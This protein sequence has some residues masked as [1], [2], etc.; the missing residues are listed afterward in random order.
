MA[1]PTEDVSF[2]DG[3]PFVRLQRVFHARSPNVRA[4][5]GAIV[6][7]VVTWLTTVVLAAISGGNV[8]WAFLHDASTHARLLLAGPVAILAEPVL[9]RTLRTA[10]GYFV[11]SGLVPEHNVARFK[12][13]LSD[14]ARLRDS[15]V[16]EVVLLFLAFAFSQRVQH[17][18]DVG[19]GWL[20]TPSAAATWYGWVSR[21]LLDFLL[22]RWL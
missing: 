14:V 8:L 6:F 17:I 10:A 19:V 4:L 21:P 7:V 9:D 22:L 18:A 12:A 20:Q 1:P 2:L 11:S 15:V 16:P 3:G 13:N 5:D